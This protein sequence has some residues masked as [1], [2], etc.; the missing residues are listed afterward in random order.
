MNL[1]PSD[2]LSIRNL[3]EDEFKNVLNQAA[4]GK[5]I[6]QK[7]S[8]LRITS[9]ISQVDLFCY[10]GIRF[11]LPK[12]ILSLVRNDD[13]DNLV[14]WHYTLSINGEL[15]EIISFTYRIEVMLPSNY[16]CS[17]EDFNNLLN[18][19][20]KKYDKQIEVFKNQLEEWITFLNPYK[21]LKHSANRLLIRAYELDK[22]LDK[23]PKHPVNE[24]E[25]RVFIESYP[26]NAE[27]ADELSGL[28][29]SIRMMAP[30]IAESFINLLIFILS[31]PEIKNNEKEMDKFIR[32][33]INY[34]LQALHDKC[35][36]I[37]KPIDINHLIVKNFLDLMKRRNDL[38]HG[39]I[40]PMKKTDEHIYFLKKIP[41]FVEWR[42]IFERSLKTRMETYTVADAQADIDVTSKLIEYLM[43]H[44]NQSVKHN[45]QILADTMDLG[46]DIKRKILGKLLPNITTDFIPKES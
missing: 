38:L 43:Q 13:S 12:G 33:P 44:L 46:Y 9:G 32:L 25:L 30:V 17:T 37:D 20:I 40:I 22:A 31:K 23:C 4:T 21:H 8:L 39:N 15:L 28:C 42:S 19:E 7:K 18:D 27:N 45:I 26:K 1:T 2:I 10:L 41:L 34:R 14:H 35:L 24:K 16:K 6:S 11:G 3:R 36:Y 29:L 5:H